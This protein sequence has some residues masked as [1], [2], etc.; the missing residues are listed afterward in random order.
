MATSI[1]LNYNGLTNGLAASRRPARRVE[2][3]RTPLGTDEALMQ[4]FHDGDDEA[5]VTLYDRYKTAIFRFVFRRV[6]DQGR[7]E[8][9]TADVFTAVV[10]YRAT[11]RPDA[12]FKTYLYRIAD[13][14]CISERQRAERRV[15]VSPKTNDSEETPRPEPVASDESPAD[16][17]ERRELFALVRRAIDRLPS[18]FRMPLLLELDD[19]GRDEIAAHLGI[20]V[21]TVKTR[22]FRARL[23]L[24][25]ILDE[26]TARA[27]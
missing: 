12:L 7:A 21:E 10:R 16:R 5:F 20:P 24:R 25:A 17:A 18:D 4:A 19:L 3:D 9:I 15:M 1:A 8:E 27:A 22:I 13:N 26:M 6:G 11:W 2:I 23:K 14:R